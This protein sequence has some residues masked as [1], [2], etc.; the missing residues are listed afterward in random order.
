MSLHEEVL[1][2]QLDE[3]WPVMKEQIDAGGSVRFGPKG[4]SMLP[5]L[6][7]GIDSVVI[8]KVPGKLKKYDLP[9][10]RR[11]SGQFV[12]HRIIAVKKSGYVMRG[13]NQTQNEYNIK[14]SQL[15]AIVTG[16]YRGDKYFDVDN[17]E[18]IK[19]VRNHVLKTDIRVFFLRIR[20]LLKRILKKLHIIK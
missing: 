19:Y 18:Y 10:Y 4:T 3:M 2:V 13:D 14:D 9:L 1:K 7:Q 11:E 5:L 12:L 8:K 17:S 6:R 20:A 15:L 16:I